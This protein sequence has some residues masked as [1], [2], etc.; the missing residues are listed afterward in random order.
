MMNALLNVAKLVQLNGGRLVGK[1]RLQKTAYFLEAKGVGYGFDFSY[2]R[3]GPYS[4][5]LANYADQAYQNNLINI[6]W[7]TSQEGVP[8]AVF[9]TN[10]AL[11]DDHNLN[12]TRSKI[13]TILKKYTALEI[14]LAATADFLKKNGYQDSFWIEMQRRKA[15]KVTNDRL[16]GAR[17]LLEEVNL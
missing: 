11:S 3:F 9:I 15:N 6:S 13:L 4:E 8:Y 1:T 14:E 17:R 12:P 7:E 16:A 2:Y 10:S 5:E